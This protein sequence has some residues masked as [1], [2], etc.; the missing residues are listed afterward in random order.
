M[1]ARKDEHYIAGQCNGNIL[2]SL[3]R[4][5]GSI[6]PPATI[7][8]RKNDE[9]HRTDTDVTQLRTLQRETHTQTM[10]KYLY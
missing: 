10:R 4:K 2:V 9:K 8:E 3:A 1:T 7:I 6:P 5:G